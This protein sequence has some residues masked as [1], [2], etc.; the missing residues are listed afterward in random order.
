MDYKVFYTEVA[1]WIY[2]A[3]QNAMK[4]GIESEAFWGWVTGSAAEMCNKYE[5]NPLVMKQMMMLAEW[6]EEAYENTK[7]SR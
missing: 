4:H 5:N 7:R 3:N 6:L 2:Q 1:D